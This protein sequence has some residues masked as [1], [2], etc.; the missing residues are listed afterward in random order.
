[1]SNFGVFKMARGL[2]KI[3]VSIFYEEVIEWRNI[4]VDNRIHSVQVVYSFITFAINSNHS[5]TTNF[6]SFAM[7]I[8]ENS[9]QFDLSLP[10]P[11]FDRMID[12][13]RTKN[14]SLINVIPTWGTFIW[15]VLSH[16]HCG[17]NWLLHYS[18]KKVL[19]ML[20][21]FNVSIYTATMT[22]L[23]LEDSIFY[24]GCAYPVGNDILQTILRET[25]FPI[26]LGIGMAIHKFW[27]L[28]QP[29][30]SPCLAS[31]RPPTSLRMRTQKCRTVALIFLI[32]K[33]I[34]FNKT[35][36]AWNLS[37]LTNG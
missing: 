2:N 9:M 21:Q 28:Q 29:N 6:P 7:R 23:N 26:I 33:L 22:F 31:T 37:I 17:N 13:S 20:W 10:N 30:S 32:N 36:L 25:A 15:E 8:W 14:L 35:K 19:K 16:H 3:Q 34:F 5:I 1:M 11:W 4:L 18:Q 27:W 12:H 24:E